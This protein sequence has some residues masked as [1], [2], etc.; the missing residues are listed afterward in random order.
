MIYCK[1][2][3]YHRMR[4]IL[5][6]GESGCPS[7]RS[8]PEGPAREVRL[9]ESWGRVRHDRRAG[10]EAT[11]TG[12]RSSVAP[13]HPG[14]RGRPDRL[15]RPSRSRS[16]GVF[17]SV[18]PCA[19]VPAPGFVRLGTVMCRTWYTTSASSRTRAVSGPVHRVPGHGAE[20]GGPAGSREGRA[21][22]LMGGS[23]D[24]LFC[25]CQR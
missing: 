25:R 2:T 22:I 12:L 3:T 19:C 1:Y 16:T 20:V 8:R 7:R 9:R 17:R 18:F 11:F 5:S 6:Q 21:Y 10:V 13:V 14:P 4:K 24:P 15:S 23:A